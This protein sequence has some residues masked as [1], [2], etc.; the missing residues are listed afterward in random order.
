VQAGV[1]LAKGELVEKDAKT[2]TAGKLGEL[3]VE[4]DSIILGKP[5][6]FDAKN[7]DDY[8]F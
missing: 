5:I 3:Q 7:I 1:A 6:A 4:G 8:D 2:F